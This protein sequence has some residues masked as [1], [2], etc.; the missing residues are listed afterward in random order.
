MADLASLA[1]MIGRLRLVVALSLEEEE[2]GEEGSVIGPPEVIEVPEVG[3][4]GDD[5]RLGF[6][7]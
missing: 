2:P 5:C 6:R 7:G 3:E 1:L 4:L